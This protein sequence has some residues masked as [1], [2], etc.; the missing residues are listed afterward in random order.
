MTA[1]ERPVDGALSCA[2]ALRRELAVPFDPQGTDLEGLRP[3][4]DVA[5]LEARFE[6]PH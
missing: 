2:T 6:P 5:S 3:D 4:L 1:V